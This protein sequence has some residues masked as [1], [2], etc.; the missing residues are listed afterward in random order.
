[1]N[2]VRNLTLKILIATLF[3]AFLFRGPLSGAQDKFSYVTAPI[4]TI[5]ANAGSYIGEQISFFS[6]LRKLASENKEL[7]Q[8]VWKLENELKK[9][10]KFEQ[11]NEE[12]R[13]LL[14]LSVKGQTSVLSARIIGWK[15]I[16]TGGVFMINKGAD[17]GLEKGL[18]V[19]YEGFLVGE[20]FEV[21]SSSSYVRA[22][23]HP[24]FRIS[25]LSSRLGE[26]SLGL[27]QGYMPGK[28]LMKDIYNSVPLENGDEIITS[29]KE[30]QIPGGLIL[31][32][33][34]ET[35]KTGV[36]KEAIVS[37]PVDIRS[38]SEVFILQ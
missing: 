38:L 36:L 5:F 14:A 21:D 16:S 11:E 10:E 20:V 34:R 23:Y 8:R 2:N 33:V 25:A 29:G 13:R 28:L 27:I 26:T 37:L 35:K 7:S 12:L 19:V 31:G 9:M 15:S 32:N 6:S 4:T 22:S 24:S 1:M 30:P 3:L 17:D 18:A